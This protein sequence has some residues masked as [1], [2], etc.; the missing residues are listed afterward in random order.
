MTLNLK[1]AAEQLA[2]Y[3]KHEN[4]LKE[5]AKFLTEYMVYF[6]PQKAEGPY[7]DVYMYCYIKH[8]LI[9]RD[10]KICEKG[11]SKIQRAGDCDDLQDFFDLVLS[12]GQKSTLQE[13]Q[14]DTP[15]HAL[16]KEWDQKLSTELIDKFIRNADLFEDDEIDEDI[17]NSI[18]AQTKCSDKERGEIHF[19]RTDFDGFVK[20][21]LTNEQITSLQGLVNE[22]LR[23]LLQ[24]KWNGTLPEDIIDLIM[25]VADLFDDPYDSKYIDY[26][27]CRGTYMLHKNSSPDE[28]DMFDVNDMYEFLKDRFVDDAIPTPNQEKILHQIAK[29]MYDFIY[30]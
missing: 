15:E 2:A 20:E 27:I 17:L 26:K 28:K 21:N 22:V 11:L 30:S 3:T 16:H 12:I 9:T 29:R 18:Y 23:F 10:T 24:K 4:A 5:G 25:D 6:D 1:L 14:H 8:G 19:Q 7:N 13:K